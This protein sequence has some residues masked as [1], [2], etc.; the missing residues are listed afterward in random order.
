MLHISREDIARN[1]KDAGCS[2]EFSRKFMAA[3][4]DTER[5]RMLTAQRDFLLDNLH[6]AQEKLSC[7][8][9]LIY[10]MKKGENY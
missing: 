5:M 1:L 7:M 3:V 8:D 2:D 6:T 10:Q 4:S 9:Y